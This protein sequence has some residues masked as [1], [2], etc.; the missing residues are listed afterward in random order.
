MELT[1]KQKTIKYVVFCLI[2]LFADLI[3][4]TAGLSIELGGARCFIIIPTVICLSIREDEKI[5]ALIGLYAGLLWDLSAVTHMGF[6]CI[7]LML[8]CYIASAL[9]TYFVRS[10]FLTNFVFETIAS[11]LYSVI[12]WL[13]FIIIKRVSGAGESIFYFYIPSAIYTAFIGIPIYFASRSLLRKF[14]A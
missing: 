7:F 3:Q 5:S 1:K 11:F 6:N 12:Y 2:I 10:V 13:I 9:E 14:E 4:N 8:I